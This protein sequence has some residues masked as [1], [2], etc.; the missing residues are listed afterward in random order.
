M[1]LDDKTLYKI[2]NNFCKITERMI[3]VVL[4]AICFLAIWGI[5]G[6]SIVVAKEED[7]ASGLFCYF[8][9]SETEAGE[10]AEAIGAEMVAFEHGVAEVRA[11]ED[12]LSDVE[13]EV[14]IYT[15]YIYT[16]YDTAVGGY[17]GSEQWYIEAVGLK[18]AWQYARGKDV[19]VAVIDSGIDTTHGELKGAVVEAVSVIPD[20]AY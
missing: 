14:E 18:E 11:D 1:I 7:E 19:L 10:I 20:E 8:A 16:T 3:T 15:E 17:I 12:N 4:V 6:K 2:Y 5:L 13:T 9:E